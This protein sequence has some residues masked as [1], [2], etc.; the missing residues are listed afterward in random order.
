MAINKFFNPESE[1]IDDDLEV[2]VDEIIKAYSV[3]DITHEKDEENDIIP[4]IGYFEIIK[5][6]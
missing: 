3:R 4:K 1:E 5:S 6:L 2:I